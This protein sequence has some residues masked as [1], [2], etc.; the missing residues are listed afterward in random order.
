[1]GGS[2]SQ[3]GNSSMSG[4]AVMGVSAFYEL[5]SCNDFLTAEAIDN[6]FENFLVDG[7][8]VEA[9]DF[10][11]YSWIPGAMYIWNLNT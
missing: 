8:F 6:S 11:Y 9:N 1:M 4:G 2:V 3:G 5:V 10:V 7:L